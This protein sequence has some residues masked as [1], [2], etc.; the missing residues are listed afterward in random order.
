MGKDANS[1]DGKVI[2]V[3]DGSSGIGLATAQCFARLKELEG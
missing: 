1:F 3:T 2:V